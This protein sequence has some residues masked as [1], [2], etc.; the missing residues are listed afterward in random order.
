[1]DAD[2]QFFKLATIEA[3]VPEN[4]KDDLQALLQ[5]D[6]KDSNAATSSTLGIKERD[7]L[8]IGTNPLL[9][10]SSSSYSFSDQMSW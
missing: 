9:S 2:K 8:F 7:V 10:R 4:S 1:M 5:G 3:F 6:D